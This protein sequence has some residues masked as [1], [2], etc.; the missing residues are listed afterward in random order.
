MKKR[1]LIRITSFY[2]ALILVGIGTYVSVKTESEKYK[3]QIK[4]S[5]ESALETLSVN[6]GNIEDALKKSVYSSGTGQ[7]ASLSVLLS[8]KA[9]AAKSAIASLPA[10]SG[11]LTSINKFLSQVGEYSLHLSKKAAAGE[12]IQSE[13]RENLLKLSQTAGKIHSGI[14]DIYTIYSSGG[15]WDEQIDSQNTSSQ[16]YDDVQQIE[17]ALTDYPTLIYDGPFSDHISDKKSRLLEQSEYVEPEF[18]KQIAA[19]AIGKNPSDLADGS[20]SQGEIE[21]YGFNEANDGFI[22]VTKKGGYL[23]YMRRVLPKG[24]T[25][26]SF[27]QAEKKAEEFLEKVGY[28]NMQSNY[29]F[30]NEGVCVIN[31]AFVN[32]ST[33]CYTDLI[34][35]GVDLSSGTV[36]F[37]DA[38]QYIKNHTDRNILTPKYSPEQARE[39]L[40]ENL[41]VKSQKLALIPTASKEQVHCFEFTCT[42]FNNDEVLVYINTATLKEEQIFILL[43]TDGGILTK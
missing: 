41:S 26:F 31:F 18:A 20:D 4:Y 7:L 5:Y 25:N 35:V 38:K 32:G 12:Q 27:E 24:D 37:F 30:I 43:K 15:A 29:Y 23:I 40:S 39:V 42:G 17:H 19:D 16:F 28:K 9:A 33:V 14:N 6:I 3:Q 36:V 1:V 21:T 22:A 8:T 11:E 2:V 13:E 10:N 34:K